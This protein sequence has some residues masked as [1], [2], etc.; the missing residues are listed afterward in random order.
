MPYSADPRL[1]A[2]VEQARQ[3]YAASDIDVSGPADQGLNPDHFAGTVVLPSTGPGHYCVD[4]IDDV[5][6]PGAPFSL[7]FVN[8]NDMPGDGEWLGTFR[9]FP[10]VVAEI[11]RHEPGRP[12]ADI[13]AAGAATSLEA[14]ESPDGGLRERLHAA[15]FPTS[16]TGAVRGVGT[17]TSSAAGQPHQPRDRDTGI[18]R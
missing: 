10:E 5:A 14:P 1:L 3:H 6:L 8:V 16:A 2:L 4:V 18:E 9:T 15:G 13:D 17:S 12:P 11:D 7:S